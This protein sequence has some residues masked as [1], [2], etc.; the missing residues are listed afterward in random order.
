MT[1]PGKPVIKVKDRDDIAE[2]MSHE[3]YL[4]LTYSGLSVVN[5]NIEARENDW[6]MVLP[7]PS[8]TKQLRQGSSVTDGSVTS[9][10]SG[11]GQ[12]GP[13]ATK[14]ASTGKLFVGGLAWQTTEDSLRSHF[15][16]FGPLQT[17]VVMEGRGYGFVFFRNPDDAQRCLRKFVQHFVDN[18]SVE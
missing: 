5:P 4:R 7:K 10:T 15:K 16:Q 11:G 12:V 8:S 6:K 3:S 13:A 14:A 2:D 1:A 18:K 9:T 17:V